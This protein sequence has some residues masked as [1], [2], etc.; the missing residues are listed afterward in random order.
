[1]IEFLHG[2]CEL[3]AAIDRM[4]RA[5]RRL[6]KRQLTWFRSDPEAVWLPPEEEQIA[7]E[8]ES[9]WADGEVVGG[10]ASAA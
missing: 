7:S 2:A 6:A 4:T 3:R 8:L 5:T 9:F 1:M 10:G